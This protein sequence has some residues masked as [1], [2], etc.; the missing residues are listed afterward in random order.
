MELRTEQS[1]FKWD[2]KIRG[3]SRDFIAGAVVFFPGSVITQIT[4]ASFQP[5]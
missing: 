4:I 2:K 1:S 3:D 5:A